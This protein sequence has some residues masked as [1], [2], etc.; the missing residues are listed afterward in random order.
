MLKSEVGSSGARARRAGRIREESGTCRKLQAAAKGKGGATRIEASRGRRS[1]RQAAGWRER[2]VARSSSQRRT[3]GGSA[4]ASDEDIEELLRRAD[5]ANAAAAATLPSAAEERAIIDAAE[6]L[7]GGD[8]GVPP[9][10]R[11]AI[12]T[13]QNKWLDFLGRH[14]VQYGF[15]EA[16]GP[17]LELAVKFS[18]W[19]FFTRKVFSTTG[20][21]GMGDSWGLLAVPYLLPKYVFIR[22]GYPGWAGSRRA[23]GQVSAL[24]R[25]AARD[26]AEAEGVEQALGLGQRPR[27]E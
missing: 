16:E 27:A 18:T 22:C 11:A 14:G 9:K 20:C 13:L 5:E 19:G 10:S 2:M 4:A 1:A 25:R 26:L 23:A 15:R 7:A 17:T 24:P 8:A 3:S 12:S 21:D 6:A